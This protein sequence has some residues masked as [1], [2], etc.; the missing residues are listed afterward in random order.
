MPG[1]NSGPRPLGILDSEGCWIGDYGARAQERDNMFNPL[2]IAAPAG[3][4]A[5]TEPSKLTK[6]TSRDTLYV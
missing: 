2:P 4:I 1:N 5:V 6:N 3:G